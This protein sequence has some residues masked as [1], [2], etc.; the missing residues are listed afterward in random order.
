LQTL[1]F[2]LNRADDTIQ[3]LLS[4]DVSLFPGPSE[5]GYPFT[6]LGHRY[7]R[8]QYIEPGRINASTLQDIREWLDHAED[9]AA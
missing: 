2:L 9:A 7:I 1:A 4:I 6:Q 8:K 3:Q 5:P